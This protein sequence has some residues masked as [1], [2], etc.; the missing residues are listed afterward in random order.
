[1]GQDSGVDVLYLSPQQS[2]T[3]A[4]LAVAAERAGVSAVTLG[5]TADV[6]LGESYLY[7]GPR[8]C[9]WAR[10]FLHVSP[11]EPTDD[12]LPRLPWRF[13]RRDIAL[14]TL[15]EARRRSAL[16]FVKAPREKDFEA[17]FYN[18]DAL[19]RGNDEQ[20]L[21][22]SEVVSFV[23]E[24][25]LL[26]LDGAVTAG[27]RYMS[28]GRLDVRPLQEDVDAADVMDFA[29]ALLADAADSLPSAVTLD[30]GWA[31]HADRGDGGWAVVE[32][33]MAWFSNIYDCDPNLALAVVMRSAGPTARLAARDLAF[34][35][36]Q[37]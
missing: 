25:R 4:A 19:P 32:A 33:N 2:S 34:V 13:R 24:Y 28:S 29:R 17:G 18:S 30:V 10:E 37:P 7:G 23:R 22:V 31:E 20:L 26:V 16:A 3:T 35:R 12:W 5:S 8:Y 21:L 9:D 1:M 15:G 6:V 14:T 11:I 36:Q 27:S